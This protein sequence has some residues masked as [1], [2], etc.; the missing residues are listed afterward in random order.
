MTTTQLAKPRQFTSK[1]FDTVNDGKILPQW[2][3][4]NLP[5]LF[6]QL[7]FWLAL[8][9]WTA[10]QAAALI[11]GKTPKGTS[12]DTLEI[13]GDINIPL[14]ARGT[15]E[16][17]CIRNVREAEEKIL[18]AAESHNYDNLSPSEW[19][20]FAMR[21]GI[22]PGWRQF[23]IDEGLL[24]CRFVLSRQRH[25]AGMNQGRLHRHATAAVCGSCAPTKKPCR[26]KPP[27]P[28]FS[29]PHTTLSVRFGRCAFCFFSRPPSESGRAGSRCAALFPLTCHASHPPQGHPKIMSGVH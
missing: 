5:V 10:A 21:W 28:A 20:S 25:G 18:D 19:V 29:L 14:S 7:C 27:A 15:R 8:P 24:L 17:T 13:L 3:F 9:K 16:V 12:K 1:D 26:T 22:T 2:Y 6:G 4:N 23:A 11:A